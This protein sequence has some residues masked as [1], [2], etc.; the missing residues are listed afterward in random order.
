MS[1]KVS[2]TPVGLRNDLALA[3]DEFDLIANQDGFVGLK[4]APAVEV[5]LQS[6]SYPLM[7]VADKLRRAQTLRNEDGTYTGSDLSA[8]TDSYKTEDHGHEVRVDDRN[9]NRFKQVLNSDMQAAEIARDVVLASHNARVIDA[10]LAIS[11]STAVTDNSGK[12][13]TDP[14]SDIIGDVRRARIKVRNRGGGKANVLCVEFEVFE[15]MRD[16][17]AILEIIKY[18]GFDNPKKENISATVLAQ[19]LGLD[20]IIVADALTNTANRNATPVLAS[21]WPKA[22][23]LLFTRSTRGTAAKVQ[24]M[25]TFHWGED[26]SRVGG[27]FEKYRSEAKRGYVVRA[28]METQEKVVY[29][30]AGEKLTSVAA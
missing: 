23:A 28:R 18:S 30:A 17:D 1:A 6:D 16:N 9:A 10:A 11:N 24:F 20:E 14:L 25:R 13:W 27:S 22:T 5:S 29:A 21:M 4:I 19:A 12:A 8:N 2:L 3:L 26:G 7:K 15:A